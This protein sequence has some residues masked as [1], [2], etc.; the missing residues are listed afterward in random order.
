MTVKSYMFSTVVAGALME[1]KI[2]GNKIPKK[3][4][5]II[6]KSKRNSK[7]YF[8]NIEVKMPD[9]TTRLLGPISFK[10]Q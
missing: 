9:G 10:L 4:K 6:K 8:E 7:V 2:R 3:I 5:D 1:E